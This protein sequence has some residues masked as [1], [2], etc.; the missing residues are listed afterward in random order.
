MCEHDP[1]HWLPFQ[2]L[3]SR[4]SFWLN[5]FIWTDHLGIWCSGCYGCLLSLTSIF[6][7]Q[8]ILQPGWIGS[9]SLHSDP[10]QSE[11]NPQNILVTS[12]EM[13]G[14]KHY[15]RR[16]LQKSIID[17]VINAKL[18][19][20]RATLLICADTMLSNRVNRWPGWARLSL[21]V[22]HCVASWN[23]RVF[24]NTIA[25]E[26]NFLP[27]TKD[28]KFRFCANFNLCIKCV[29]WTLIWIQITTPIFVPRLLCVC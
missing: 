26:T 15:L 18:S 20:W 9:C 22:F 28:C 23:M 7:L 17:D 14:K 25:V 1:D 21:G 3:D 13:C 5:L 11:E 10:P 4:S 19:L 12:E 8:E 6:I 24:F 2:H 29:H 16:G 27:I